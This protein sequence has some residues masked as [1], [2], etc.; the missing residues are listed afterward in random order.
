MKTDHEHDSRISE[1]ARWLA[2]E[3]NPPRPIVPAIRDRFGLTP[4]QASEAIAEAQL[5][6][7][8]AV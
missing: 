2:F 1:A 5:I 6:R 8:R 3:K 4:L 7:A